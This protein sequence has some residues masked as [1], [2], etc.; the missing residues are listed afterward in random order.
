[1][2]CPYYIYDN[3]NEEFSFTYSKKPFLMVKGEAYPLTKKS[4][5]KYFPKQKQFIEEY[6]K[7]HNTN[8]HSVAPVLELFNALKQKM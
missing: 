8:I 1:M 5:I 4:L 3:I 2:G 6:L 7:E